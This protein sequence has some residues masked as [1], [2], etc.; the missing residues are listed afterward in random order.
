MTA[1]SL[2]CGLKT[3]LVDVA[4]LQFQADLAHP[5]DKN[6]LYKSPTSADGWVQAHNSIRGE[7][8]QM[9]LLI[10]HLGERALEPW[11]IAAMRAWWA[12]HKVHV[13]EHHHNEDGIVT[14]WLSKRVLLPERLT[15][16]HGLISAHEGVVDAL[17]A[18]SFN[19]KQLEGVWAQYE[20]IM[21]P[22]LIEEEQM[23]LPLV[24]AYFTPAEYKAITNKIIAASGKAPLGAFFYWQASKDSNA[25]DTTGITE[26]GIKKC[27][28]AFLKAEGAPA[29]LRPLIWHLQIKSASRAYNKASARHAAALFSGKQPMQ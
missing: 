19:A 14:P 10:V 22:H 12:A 11:E 23:A 3:Q 6:D 9:R 4:D 5:P 8:S 2:L 15:S 13:H 17:F 18:S 1:D 26:A 24:R 27:V 20:N 29:P 7:L 21:L 28:L 25:G 16:D